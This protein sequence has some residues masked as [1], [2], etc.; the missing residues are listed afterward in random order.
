MIAPIAHTEHGGAVVQLLVRGD[1]DGSCELN[2]RLATFGDDHE[3]R[4]LFY[5]ISGNTKAKSGS[6]KLERNIS[7]RL[8]GEKNVERF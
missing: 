6:K 8:F 1:R 5:M 4:K 7:L 3:A 2:S